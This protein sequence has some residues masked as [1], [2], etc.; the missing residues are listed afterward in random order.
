MW[1]G[2]RSAQGIFRVYHFGLR[3]VVQEPETLKSKR[4]TLK[5][6]VVRLKA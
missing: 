3:V 4:Y 6:M 1:G 5:W 2:G